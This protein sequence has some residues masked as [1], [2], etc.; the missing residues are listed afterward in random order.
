MI[1]L[2]V[3]RSKRYVVAVTDDKCV[4]VFDND[5]GKLTE[6]SQRVMPKRPCAVQITPDDSTILVGDKFG[7][8]YSL[9]LLPSEDQDAASGA[10]EGTPQP[11]NQFKP[12]A[13]N[14]TVH[15]KRNRDALAAQMQ[16]KN[17]TPRKEALKFEH[18]LLLGHVSMLTDMKFVTCQ[19]D[20]QARGYIITADRDEHIRISRGPPQAHIIEGFCLGHTEF[21]SKICQVGD[22]SLLVSG[23]GDAWL[24]VWEWWPEPK[25]RRRI[26]LHE[27]MKT[28]FNATTQQS[29]VIYG[30][31]S[32]RITA[33]SGDEDVIA[34][35]CEKVKGLFIFTRSSLEDS[36]NGNVGQRIELAHYPLDVAFEGHTMI[37]SV[38]AREESGTANEQRLQLIRLGEKNGNLEAE[39]SANDLDLLKTLNELIDPT[40]ASE[41]E[42]DGLLYGVADLRKRRDQEAHDGEQE[43]ENATTADM[44][45]S[46]AA[47]DD[48]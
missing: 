34:V 15:S 42:L 47:I 24:G 13:T 6:L 36:T 31:W 46:T 39:K 10:Q 2:T 25:L 19:S 17:F 28:L 12:S 20:V 41:K 7:D 22:S 14:L 5:H 26:N 18:K 21:V 44:D 29:P 3:S 45:T 37:V 1:K 30:I 38:D 4:R 27:E 40:S 32:G 11:E 8:V 9:P 33:D 43:N 48:A 35:A 23:G 16:Q